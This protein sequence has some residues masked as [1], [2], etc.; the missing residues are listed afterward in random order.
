M[1]ANR[2]IHLEGVGKKFNLNLAKKEGALFRFLSFTADQQPNDFWA[3]RNINFSPKEE[4][5]TGIIGSNGSGKSTLLRTIAGIYQPDEGN[6]VIGGEVV[7]LSGF[8]QGLMPK[9]TMK[10]NIYLT[11]TFLG[12]GQK[13]I[14]QKFDEIVEFS[15]LKD[16]INTKVY[17][18]STGMVSRLSFSATIFCVKHKNP[19][20]ILID[21]ALDTGADLNFREKAI[22]K[23]EELINSGSSVV[24]VSH[25]L[26][27]IN[28]YCAWV[29]WMENG[30][31]VKSGLPQQIIS[32]YIKANS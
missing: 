25:D 4:Q 32:E 9:L 23:M 31:V 26:G 30:Q 6:I 22:K 11:G 8:G 5:I 3:L 21:E 7:Y 18:F 29:L 10:E 17:Q 12:L 28:Q 2:Q 13:E 20:I 19:E 27:T 14:S 1:I 16:Y 24:L 15:G